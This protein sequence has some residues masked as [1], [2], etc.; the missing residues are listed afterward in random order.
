MKWFDHHC[1]A[2]TLH[3]AKGAPEYLLHFIGKDTQ[4]TFFTYHGSPWVD[5]SVLEE[6]Q[7]WLGNPGGGRN[8][9]IC[10]LTALVCWSWKVQDRIAADA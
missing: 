6:M 3:C 10:W 7:Y 9:A 1:S 4:W 2:D 8:D 5:L